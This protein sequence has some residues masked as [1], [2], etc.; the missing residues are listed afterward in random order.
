MHRDSCWL[1]G[2]ER[3]ERCVQ[4]RHGSLRMRLAQQACWPMAIFARGKE[5]RLLWAKGPSI[6]GRPHALCSL[7]AV[8]S[9]LFCAMGPIPPGLREDERLCEKWE[10]VEAR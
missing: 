6:Y 10:I 4:S 9:A 2:I 5:I 7:D 8:K 3:H 1:M